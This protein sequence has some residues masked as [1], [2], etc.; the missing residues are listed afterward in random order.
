[1]LEESNYIIDNYRFDVKNVTRLIVKLID[2][3]YVI[4]LVSIL[5]GVLV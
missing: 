1:M 2:K 3:Q 4:L 5:D